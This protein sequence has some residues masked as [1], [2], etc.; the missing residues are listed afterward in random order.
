MEIKMAP[1]CFLKKDLYLLPIYFHGEEVVRRYGVNL[2][3]AAGQK[4]ILSIT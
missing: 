4:L 2:N 1:K 3:N